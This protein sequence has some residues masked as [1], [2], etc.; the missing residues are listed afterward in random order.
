MWI[1]FY[2]EDKGVVSV[3][4]SMPRCF[5]G[6]VLKTRL[7]ARGVFLS[8]RRHGW[9]LGSGEMLHLQMYCTIK[10]NPVVKF[11]YLMQGKEMTIAEKP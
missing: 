9:G 5:I 11:L 3:I 4:D 7:G 8:Q 1:R 2:I 6:N 10:K